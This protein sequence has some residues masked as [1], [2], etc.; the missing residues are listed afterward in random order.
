MRYLIIT[1]VRQPDNK[2]DEMIRVETKIKNRD[3]QQANIILD[4]QDKK[5]VKARL[6]SDVTVPK[7]WDVVIDYY[8]ENYKDLIEKLE[9]RYKVSDILKEINEQ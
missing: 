9:A 8:R 6:Q 1:Y 7:D 2:Y 4:F 3:T 5:V